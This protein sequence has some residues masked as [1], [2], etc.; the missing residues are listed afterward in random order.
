MREPQLGLTIDEQNKIFDR[1]QTNQSNEGRQVAEIIHSG[2]LTDARD[3]GSFLR[4]FQTP[5]P[6]VF[7]GAAAELRFAD[8][9]ISRGH[10]A[11]QIW[12]PE[13]SLSQQGG[14][15]VDVSLTG[16][17]GRT[18]SYQIKSVEGK[19]G[20]QKRYKEAMEQLS[21]ATAEGTHPVVI[22]EVNTTM[23][24]V[25]DLILKRLHGGATRESVDF[26]LYFNDGAVRIP[27]NAEIYPE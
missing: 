27:P 19:N 8:D 16:S 1:V 25:P 3:Y 26:A 14:N 11:D 7:S 15:D 12:F 17:D 2:R 23:D 18:F 13:K 6:R 24:K 20:I 22:M 5:I 4:S 21:G 10:R 9:L